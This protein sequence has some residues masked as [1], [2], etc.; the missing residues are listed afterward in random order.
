[1]AAIDDRYEIRCPECGGSTQIITRA[2]AT[3]GP[4][5]SKPLTIKQIGRSFESAGEYRTWQRENP[6]LQ[7]L[8]NNGSK[9]KN[10]KD[11]VREFANQ[12][13]KKAGYNDLED[14]QRQMKKRD[15]DTAR[16]KK[17][18]PKPFSSG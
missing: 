13:C 16:V 12:R 7:I 10:K 11:K 2:V 5:P 4:M 15:V 17:E 6:D 8:D 1:M 18:G 14:R 3:I 9:W